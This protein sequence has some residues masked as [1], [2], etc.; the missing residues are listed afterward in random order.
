[1]LED[2]WS[3]TRRST[4]DGQSST[5]ITAAVPQTLS[6][7]SPSHSSSTASVN[8]LNLSL[9]AISN[10][11]MLED[12]HLPSIF[13]RMYEHCLARNHEDS[14][15]ED[16]NARLRLLNYILQRWHEARG[17]LTFYRD[18][19]KVVGAIAKPM[20]GEHLSVAV[21]NTPVN[22][23]HV[24]RELLRLLRSE[25]RGKS[26][27]EFLESWSRVQSSGGDYAFHDLALNLFTR[28]DVLGY[29]TGSGS[30][31]G[32]LVSQALRHPVASFLKRVLTTMTRYVCRLHFN[33]TDSVS[34][35]LFKASVPSWAEE[36]TEDGI[37]RMDEATKREVAL[38]KENIRRL[39]ISRRNGRTQKQQS[40]E[41]VGISDTEP[42]VAFVRADEAQTDMDAKTVDTESFLGSSIYHVPTTS[43]PVLP[44][45]KRAR[46]AIEHEQAIPSPERR[47]DVSPASS[48]YDDN[49]GGDGDYRSEESDETDDAEELESTE[50]TLHDLLKRRLGSRDDNKTYRENVSK[51]DGHRL[52]PVD[53]DLS[54][55]M[56]SAVETNSPDEALVYGTV[57]NLCDR[58]DDMRLLA[59]LPRNDNVVVMEDRDVQVRNVENID[60]SRVEEMDTANEEIDFDDLM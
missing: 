54:P 17:R 26:M 21:E 50:N 23:Q 14:Q 57:T 4:N 58:D 16:N 37:L 11:L 56:M 59:K 30:Q 19:C 5:K 20:F 9:L 24:V 25:T 12:Q 36:D 40:E 13:V 47:H 15:D 39:L 7:T 10:I 28:D 27:G 45:S 32:S 33:M 46:F 44:Q 6:A 8:T 48:E 52:T 35:K 22:Q 51:L 34:R 29:E 43:I 38:A 18:V 42:V 3:D 53:E 49:D 31:V 60:T 55:P 2:I 1:M 41:K